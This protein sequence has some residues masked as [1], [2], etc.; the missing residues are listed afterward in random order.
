MAFLE[1][2]AFCQPV[3]VLDSTKSHWRSLRWNLHSI[4]Q[5][6]YL[7]PSLIWVFTVFKL[8]NW[9]CRW[10]ANLIMFLDS[11]INSKLVVM[12]EFRMKRT[13]SHLFSKCRMFHLRHSQCPF[14]RLCI[15]RLERL[16]MPLF[17]SWIVCTLLQ[18]KYQC[19]LLMHCWKKRKQSPLKF[20]MTSVCS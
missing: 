17:K 20:I 9:H 19:L 11:Y 6:T 12:L 15:L 4:K 13:M 18:G 5:F 1:L 8:W 14:L 3:L 7:P 10:G 16:R 2:I